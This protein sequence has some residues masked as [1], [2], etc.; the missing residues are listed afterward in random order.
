MEEWRKFRPSS[1]IGFS[2]C[3]VS[4]DTFFTE[5]HRLEGRELKVLIDN[6]FDRMLLE[7]NPNTLVRELH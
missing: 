5:K 2:F 6:S 7:P 1:G 3:F 4:P